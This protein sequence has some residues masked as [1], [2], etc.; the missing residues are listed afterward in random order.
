[1]KRIILLATFLIAISGNLQAQQKMSKEDMQKVYD[2]YGMPGDMHK[3]MAKSA[4]TW[5]AE[6]TMWG[7]DPSMAPT[8]SKGTATVK[9]VLGGRFQ[10]AQHMGTMNGKPFEG[11]SI[12]GYDNFKKVFQDTWVDNM[13]TG[14]MTMEGT[15]DAAGKMIHFKGMGFD[16]VSGKDFMV[17]KE[18]TFIN[19]NTQKM[20]MY[21]TMPGAME[22]KSMEVVLKRDMTKK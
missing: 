3:M 21:M 6:V 13:G 19:D 11:F 9:M 20:E 8:K 5:N 18:V 1:M 17:R 10:H 14:I 4:G 7:M 2:A 16:P 12:M 22:M 15:W